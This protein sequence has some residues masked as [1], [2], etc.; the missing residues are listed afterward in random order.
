MRRVLIAALATGAA[1]MATP[2]YAADPC[3][4]YHVEVGGQAAIACV[5][6]FVGGNT[7]TGSAG[8]PT[9]PAELTDITALLNG[10][11]TD[12]SPAYAPGTYSSLDVSKILGLA[13]GLGGANAF[14]LTDK[15]GNTVTMSGLTVLGLHFGNAPDAP[16]Q[17]LN[18]FYLFD[19]GAASS[20]QV[21]LWAYNSD[22]KLV[23]NGQGSSNAEVYTTGTPG[24]P[25]PATW[26]MMLLGFGGI[27]MAMRRGRKAAGLPQI[28]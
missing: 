17:P 14:V 7:I 6:Y 23:L 18:A 3:H 20:S 24:V 1:A 8:D 11:A 28:A 12:S 22:G 16:D 27:G 10:P 2:S 19:L 13:S 21:S 5:G 9:T 15:N 25:E 26:G 4:D